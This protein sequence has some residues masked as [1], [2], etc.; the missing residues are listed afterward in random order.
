MKPFPLLRHVALFA[1]L[2]ATP[3]ISRAGAPRLVEPAVRQITATISPQQRAPLASNRRPSADLQKDLG[4]VPD[5]LPMTHLM[6]ALHRPDEQ[7]RAL[8]ALMAEQ[9]TPGTA[10]YR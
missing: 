9:T 8:A 5:D 7:E 4:R 3:A 1:L 6:L 2:L 10:N